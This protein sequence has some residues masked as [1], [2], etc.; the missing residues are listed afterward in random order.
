MNYDKSKLAEN[1]VICL[2][3]ALFC[4]FKKKGGH[5]MGM[6]EDV[7]EVAESL[8]AI[9]ANG[10]NIMENSNAMA[11]GFGDNVPVVV[12][13]A[14]ISTTKRLVWFVTANSFLAVY[15]TMFLKYWKDIDVSMV[16][17]YV[18]GIAVPTIIMW[19]TKSYLE[20]KNDVPHVDT[21]NS[22]LK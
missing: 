16:L 4:K 8:E 7:K 14:Y 12:S 13:K 11:E 18:V 6:I 20:K 5:K 10:A 21:I 2:Y 3:I 22:E 19:G 17:P 9:S 15:G 1:K